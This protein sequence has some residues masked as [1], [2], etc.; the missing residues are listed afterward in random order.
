MADQ[1][2]GRYPPY[3]GW[4]GDQGQ[5]HVRFAAPARGAF[6][7]GKPR[8]PGRG[9]APWRLR[10]RLVTVR[11]QRGAPGAVRAS[12]FECTDTD[13]DTDRVPSHPLGR[14]KRNDQ[15][16]LCICI[17]IGQGSSATPS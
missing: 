8:G 2:R 9:I 12:G 11:C 6:R 1:E 7:A 5:G 16:Y 14:D 15:L 10:A 3:T 4:S 13:T 17:C